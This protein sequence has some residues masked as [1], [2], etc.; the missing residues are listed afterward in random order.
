MDFL[1][2]FENLKIVKDFQRKLSKKDYV[3]SA[4]IT[5]E[6]AKLL[7]E[8]IKII[9]EQSMVKNGQE[10][11]NLVRE[12]G[13]SFIASDPLQFSIGNIIKR[14]LFIIREEIKK[15]EESEVKEMEFKLKSITSLNNLLDPAL[16]SDAK[17]LKKGQNSAQNLDQIS[18][19]VVSSVEE[20]ITELET[21]NDLIKPQADEHIKNEDIILTANSSDQLIDFFSGAYGNGKKFKVIIAES[22]PSLNGI[23]QAKNLINKGIDATV[24]DDAAVYAVMPKITKVVIGTRAILANGGLISYNGV[25]NVCLC[26]NIFNVPV[27]VVGSS[28]K[29]TPLYP[30]RYESF[31][32]Y[33]S[34]DVLFGKDIKYTGDISNI[35]FNTPAFDYVPPELIT[36][37]I[38]N[39]GSQ[40]PFYI[41]RLFNEL[42][43]QE[44]YYL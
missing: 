7:K 11:V 29:L 3:H 23:N 6:T 37:Y 27:V 18:D 19:N 2:T 17:P 10:L 20:L 35:K 39:N 21:M 40:N 31:N 5:I 13:K 8:I 9:I 28:F 1:S 26:A 42:Y 32:E 36:V 25:Y 4:E 14:I 38:T 34:P 44:D 33:L 24:I 41:Y 12:L 16:N 43:N 22:A 15:C 30:F